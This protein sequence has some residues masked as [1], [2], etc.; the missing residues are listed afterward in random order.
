M[1]MVLWLYL[2]NLR[3]GG[4][5]HSSSTD[6]FDQVQ[7]D[8]QIWQRRHWI[9]YPCACA[10]RRWL[11]DIW[12]NSGHSHTMRN[13][14]ITEWCPTEVLG[15]PNLLCYFQTKIAWNLKKWVLTTTSVFE[16]NVSAHMECEGLL[17]WKNNTWSHV[18][19]FPKFPDIQLK[20]IV[21][22]GSYFTYWI[23]NNDQHLSVIHTN[24]ISA[25]FDFRRL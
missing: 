10:G 21:F 16:T 8:L 11:I 9:M 15:L 3:G 20:H 25:S 22:A 18:A 1:V 23:W 14:D 19:I 7:F 2:I 12:E 5:L 6:R 13:R 4:I 24:W 17:W